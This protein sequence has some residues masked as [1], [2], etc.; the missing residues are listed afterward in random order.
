MWYTYAPMSNDARMFRFVIPIVPNVRGE[1][2]DVP[3]QALET[4]ARGDTLF[5]IDPEPYEIAVRQLEAQVQRH[6]AELRLA[7]VNVERARNLLKVQAA[8]QIDLDTWTANR[9][10]AIAA[11][12]G[13]NAQLDNAQWQLQE[14]TVRAPSE[15]YV[16]NLQVRP[17][18]VVTTIPAASPMAFV[19][20][21]ASIVLASFSQ[22]AIR[23]VKVGDPADVVFVNRP[24][25]TH[26]GRVERVVAFSG[27]SQM[28]A[29]G[30]LPSLTGTP[31]TD[32]W[33]LSVELDDEE[34]ARSL[35]QGTSGTV[36][37]YT[38]AGKP[39]H[40][41]SKVAMRMSAWLGYLTSP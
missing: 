9:D 11:I 27:Q 38:D 13:A 17:G 30:Q 18:N 24:G 26:G 6:E 14:T 37:I 33:V 15:G 39:V 8:A 29:S 7:E 1:V 25:E 34:L 41:I 28:T 40:M 5:Q 16:V 19:S 22:S 31:V 32:R 35:P 23:R 36:A 10:V 12:A 20:N 21:E 4:V 3:V 2:V